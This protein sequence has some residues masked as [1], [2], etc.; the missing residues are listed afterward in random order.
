MFASAVRVF[1]C[2]FALAG[3]ANVL[4]YFVLSDGFGIRVGNDGIIRA[5]WP[6]LVFE[7]GG[8]DG[9]DEFYPD[10]ALRNLVVAVAIAV[11]ISGAWHLNRWRSSRSVGE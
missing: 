11:V 5:G 4:S 9:R 2:V 3:I 6:F 1:L 7:R 8:I 10:G